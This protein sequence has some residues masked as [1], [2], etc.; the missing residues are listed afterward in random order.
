MPPPWRN[1]RLGP[2]RSRKS[3]RREPGALRHSGSCV[4]VHE[5]VFRLGQRIREGLTEMYR[6]LGVPVVVSGFGSVF[7]TYFLEGPVES[8]E[9][10]LRNDVELF[11]GYRRA[12]LAP[13]LTAD[14]AV[15]GRSFGLHGKASIASRLIV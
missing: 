7:V 3:W 6:G 12:L 5:H 11:V 15:K 10:L 14:F 4:A 1:A 8:Y 2:T 9:D 13:P